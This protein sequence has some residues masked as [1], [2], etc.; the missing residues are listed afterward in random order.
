VRLLTSSAVLGAYGNKP[1]LNSEAWAAYEAFMA[2]D[3]IGFHAEPAG[4]QPVWK[5]LAAR[6][7]ASPKLWMDAYLAAFA[8]TGGYRLVTTDGAFKQFADLD[9]LVLG[10]G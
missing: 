2:D 3:R 10:Q 4:L 7:T 6:R 9:L 1:L 8:S 5:K